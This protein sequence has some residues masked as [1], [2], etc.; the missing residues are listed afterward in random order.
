MS[1]NWKCVICIFL[2][3]FLSCFLFFFVIA[4]AFKPYMISAGHTNSTTAPTESTYAPLPDLDDEFDYVENLSKD[5]NTKY[6]LEI[7][8]R[9]TELFWMLAQLDL[10]DP[11]YMTKSDEIMAEIIR[12]QELD[13]LY[14]QDYLRMAEGDQHI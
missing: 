2:G 14:L 9:I 5:D 13:A 10:H 4:I 12:L 7:C 6:R 11:D 1:N 3:L 8:E